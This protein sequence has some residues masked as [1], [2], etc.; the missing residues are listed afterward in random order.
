METKE[1]N[2]NKGFSSNLWLG[3]IFISGGAIF[4]FNQTFD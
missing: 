4:L 3:L 1:N 2:N